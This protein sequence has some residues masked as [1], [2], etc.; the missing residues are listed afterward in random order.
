MT[1]ASP[2]QIADWRFELISENEQWLDMAAARFRD[3]LSSRKIDCESRDP[4]SCRHVDIEYRVVAGAPSADE[5]HRNRAVA[6]DGERRGRILLLRGAEFRACIQLS[7]PR[8]QISGPLAVYPL[9]L[10]FRAFMIEADGSLV[11][12]AAAVEDQG[13][14]WLLTG[15]SGSGKSTFASLFPNRAVCDEMAAVRR[16][17]GRLELVSLPFWSGRSAVAPLEAVLFLRHGRSNRRHPL[18]RAKALERLRRQVFWPTWQARSITHTL[19][20]LAD[21]IESTPV[22]DLFFRPDRSVW[23]QLSSTEPRFEQ[24]IEPSTVS[25]ATT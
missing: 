2:I 12:H 19:D 1:S 8:I 25:G 11:F 14:A 21:L 16:Q 24:G 15:P 22:D 13:K 4:A 17:N 20:Q 3:F 10:V 9:D 6:L 7:P 18:D 23:R 5:L